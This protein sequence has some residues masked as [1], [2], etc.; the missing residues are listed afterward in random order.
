MSKDNQPQQKQ[1]KVRYNETSSVFASQF[2]LNSSAEDVTVNFS[3]GPIIDPATGESML[4]I[5]TRISM[6]REGAKRLYATLGRVLAEKA[7]QQE[8]LAAAQFP[9]VQ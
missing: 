1:I 2:L 3:S 8:D 7:E 4:P 9:K 5:H 6:S